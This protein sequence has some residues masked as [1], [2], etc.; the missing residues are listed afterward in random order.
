MYFRIP[1]I[2]G[3]LVLLGFSAL[4]QTTSGSIAAT[5]VDPQQA[6][7]AGATVTIR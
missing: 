1:I 3:L 4:A 6:A 2:L 5:V 7:I